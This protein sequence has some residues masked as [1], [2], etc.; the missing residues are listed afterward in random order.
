ME[1]VEIKLIGCDEARLRREILA[2]GGR[3]DREERQVNTR[4]SSDRLPIEG[5]RYLRL[6]AV[7]S[8]Q[9]PVR[10]ELT[11]KERQERGDARINEEYTVTVSDGPG[12]LEIFRRIGLDRQ[13]TG[14]KKRVRYLYR[15]FRI[16][17]DCWD[18]KTL[19]YPYVEVEG[20][21]PEALEDFLQAFQIP[22][23]CVSTR[24]I[25]ELREEEAR[26]RAEA[27]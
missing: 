25:G 1:E 9:E 11:L 23:E 2:R 14:R 16:E 27:N 15:D 8:G 13:E 5:D 3:L 22:K 19:S 18:S 24:S 21:S 26:K 10:Y 7:S 12:L 17:F 6:R 4:I 20:P